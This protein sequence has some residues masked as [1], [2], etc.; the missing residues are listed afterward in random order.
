M[1]ADHREDD[2]SV[3]YAQHIADVAT[4]NGLTAVATT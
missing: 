2:G 3:D 1:I 4:A